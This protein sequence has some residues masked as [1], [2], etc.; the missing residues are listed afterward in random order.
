MLR[1]AIISLVF[2]TWMF[3]A[4]AGN[5]DDTVAVWTSAE[6]VGAWLKDNFKFDQKRQ[7]I[8]QKRLKQSGP[9]GLL[10]RAPAATFDTPKGYCAD[11]AYC[12]WVSLNTINSGDNA[13]WIFINNAIGKPNLGA[14]GFTIDDKLYVMDYGAGPHW[15]QMIGVHGPYETL[16]G[17]ADF[18]ASLNIKG[19]SV[20]EVKWREMPGSYD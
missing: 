6:D 10:V 4:Q 5:F 14:T 11:A 7:K 13:R 15:K 8:I 1:L 16:E 19:F 9:S 18:L 2:V 20:G 3:P 17:Y 12:A